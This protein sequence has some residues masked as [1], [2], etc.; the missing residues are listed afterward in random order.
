MATT[1]SVPPTPDPSGRP[2]VLP[3]TISS[4][5]LTAPVPKS[6]GLQLGASK[7]PA[8][9]LA[10]VLAAEAEASGVPGGWGDGDLMD[11]NADDGDWNAFESAP[12]YD[13]NTS[14]A[15]STSGDG[16]DD[17][18]PDAGMS[19]LF[20]FSI[21]HMTDTLHPIQ[22]KSGDRCMHRE[23]HLK[24]TRGV[25]LRLPHSLCPLLRR[26]KSPPSV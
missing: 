6:R 3:S 22:T 2:P 12:S 25:L 21:I 14:F 11:V 7:K 24:W 23:V 16:F 4:P 9:A 5:D 15:A 19:F 13:A 26:R 18:V 17:A 20:L 1:A 10:A 8:G